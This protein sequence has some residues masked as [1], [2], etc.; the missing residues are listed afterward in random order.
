MRD[1]SGSPDAYYRA[2]CAWWA[3]A[4][5]LVIVEHDILPADGVIEE[6][7]D[8]HAP[9][10]SS[11][12]SLGGVTFG[13]YMTLDGTTSELCADANAYC[14][15]ALGC[16]KFSAQ[17]S[18]ALPTLIVESGIFNQQIGW[19]PRVWQLNDARVSGMLRL[20]GLTPHLHAPSIHL[21][22]SPG[23]AKLSSD[24]TY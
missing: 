2:L 8:C 7:L 14:T 24:S 19:V 12:Y 6:M 10:C 16:T 18:A 9:W 17:L 21:S 22:V 5:N 23:G 20:S 15:D 13:V 4:D 1:V 3:E 11:P